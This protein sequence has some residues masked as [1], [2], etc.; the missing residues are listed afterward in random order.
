MHG[1][2]LE[3]T[4]PEPSRQ[5]VFGNDG[6]RDLN[7]R[8]AGGDVRR[9]PGVL[10]RHGLIT[11]RV[12]G[13]DR[14]RNS[15]TVHERYG[16]AGEPGAE[17]PGPGSLHAHLPGKDVEFPR[18]KVL[19]E[20][21]LLGW[22]RGRRGIDEETVRGLRRCGSRRDGC[23]SNPQHAEKGRSHLFPASAQ[24][25]RFS[26]PATRE[27]PVR[28]HPPGTPHFDLPDLTSGRWCGLSRG[29]SLP[30][31]GCRR[32]PL[33]KSCFPKDPLPPRPKPGS[34]VRY[35]RRPFALL[36]PKHAARIPLR[37]LRGTPE[38]ERFRGDTERKL[39]RAG[40]ALPG[41]RSH[42]G[43]QRVRE[44]GGRAQAVR[45]VKLAV[46]AAA[47]RGGTRRRAASRTRA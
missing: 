24:Y 43:Q 17:S 10:F 33:P 21:H 9:D 36:L 28:G 22:R 14:Y 41:R 2:E 6:K 3:I 31:G 11:M 8:G 12:P 42:V 35:W 32:A 26:G 25:R 39:L 19:C 15:C 20:I 16:N 38:D 46:R 7:A 47:A 40:S 34:R 44:V 18:L 4:H 27:S 23:V 30:E 45:V 29:P 1:S 5:R 13:L 37:S